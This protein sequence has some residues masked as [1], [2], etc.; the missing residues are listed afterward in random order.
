MPGSSLSGNK[1]CLA[2]IRKPTESPLYPNPS[3]W[4]ITPIPV[5]LTWT[6]H[7]T[8][9]T[10]RLILDTVHTEKNQC[11]FLTSAQCGLKK[12]LSYVPIK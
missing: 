11:N 2:R 10:E 12:N 5:I 6:L 8:A 4:D 7:G 3:T 9:W 1:Q